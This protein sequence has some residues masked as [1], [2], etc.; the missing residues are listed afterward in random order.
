[1]TQLYLMQK[2]DE[3]SIKDKMKNAYFVTTNIYIIKFTLEEWPIDANDH[4]IINLE[5]FPTFS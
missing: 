2:C 4:I 5:L 3:E 1:M